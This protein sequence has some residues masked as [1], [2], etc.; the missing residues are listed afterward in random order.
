MKNLSLIL[1]GVLL[2][3]LILLYVLFFSAKKSSGISPADDT[4]SVE[5]EGIEGGIVFINM[6]S[7]YQKYQMAKD[8]AAELETKVNTSDARLQ[9]K[10]RTLQKDMEDFQYKVDRQLI[11]RANAEQEQQ[12]L[13]MR[14]QEIYQEQQQLQYQ[15]A[16]Q[17]QV[18]QNQVL[19]S[20]MDYIGSIEAENNFRFV[21]GTQF[22][23][24]V[25]YY[26]NDL[27]VTRQVLNGLNA[28]Y[29]KTRADTK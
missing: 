25:L 18:M 1:N 6:D 10:G 19:N 13:M 12:T 17:Q 4:L 16:E 22:G 23:G 2:A 28:E 8:L 7:V 26:D 5:I 9:T 20:I 29:R 21:L 27:D 14:Q 15:L 3:G 11:T 24:N